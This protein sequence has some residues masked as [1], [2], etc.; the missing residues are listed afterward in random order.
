[1]KLQHLTVIFIIIIL[2]IILILSY[3]IQTQITTATLRDNY[4]TA[5]INSIGPNKFVL[6]KV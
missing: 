6:N 1:M 5:L 4:K 3:Y 2:P